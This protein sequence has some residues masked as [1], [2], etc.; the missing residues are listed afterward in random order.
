M[1]REKSNNSGICDVK[2][3][4][5]IARYENRIKTKGSPLF[6]PK[7]VDVIKYLKKEYGLGTNSNSI[8]SVLNILGL[9]D[10]EGLVSHPKE[11][12]CRIIAAALIKFN[13]IEDRSYEKEISDF[14]KNRKK[15]IAN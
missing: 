11:E 4:I 2:K 7:Y 13:K 14:Y 10:S 6:V 9:R 8:K 12:R 3:Y 1:F 15:R 5:T